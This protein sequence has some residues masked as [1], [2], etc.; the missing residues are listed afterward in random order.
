MAFYLR[1]ARG[2]DLDRVAADSA[3]SKWFGVGDSGPHAYPKLQPH[4]ASYVT[5][6][7]GL[8]E[9]CSCLSDMRLS[10]PPKDTP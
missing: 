8:L 1:L 3:S 6:T 10:C 9:V 2:P 7:R 5:V 4:S